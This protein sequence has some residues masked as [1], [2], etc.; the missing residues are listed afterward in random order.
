MEPKATA[1]YRFSAGRARLTRAVSIFLMLCGI[2]G[3]LYYYSLNRAVSSGVPVSISESSDPN[4][5]SF[6]DKYARVEAGVYRGIK[7]YGRV[8]VVLFA[9]SFALQLF[10]IAFKARLPASTVPDP[11]DELGPV[12]IASD[13]I[14]HS[15]GAVQW[16]LVLPRDQ[17]ERLELEHTSAMEKPLAAGLFGVVFLLFGLPLA[18]LLPPRIQDFETFSVFCLG[19]LLV[20]TGAGILVFAIRK[21][22]VLVAHTPSGRSRMIFPRDASREDVIHFVTNAARRHGYPFDFG[23]G[24]AG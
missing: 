16:P 3:S 10:L 15:G 22:Y 7:T 6:E 9:A 21:R 20:A 13:G 18:V 24:L 2:N 14:A 19:A 5:L 11:L 1:G 8:V 23:Q 4:V 12:R 17:I